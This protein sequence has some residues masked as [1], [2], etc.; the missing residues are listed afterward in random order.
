MR[1]ETYCVGSWLL[2]LGPNMAG[3]NV[4]DALEPRGKRSL[5]GT[6]L[7]YYRETV[8]GEDELEDGKETGGGT[9]N[10]CDLIAKAK[11]RNSTG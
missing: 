7:E 11:K 2:D 1:V 10:L 4:G 5:D 8:T 9:D 6:L 3:D